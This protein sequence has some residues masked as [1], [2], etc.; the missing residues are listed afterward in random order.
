MTLDVR[1]L[2]CPEPVLRLKECVDSGEKHI[3][4]TCDCGSAEENI[5]RFAL[6]C[7]FTLN[8]SKN[9]DGSVVFVLKK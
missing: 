3:E 7:G 9:A 1:G 6:N 2:N 8:K 4:V 5:N